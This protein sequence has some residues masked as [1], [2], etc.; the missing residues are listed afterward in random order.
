MLDITN[1][2]IKSGTGGGRRAR[3]V[4]KETEKGEKVTNFPRSHYTLSHLLPQSRLEYSFYKLACSRAWFNF[5]C[6]SQP[7]AYC[8]E[9]HWRRKPGKQTPAVTQLKHRKNQDDKSHTTE[10][11][12]SAINYKFSNRVPRNLRIP[13]RHTLKQLGFGLS[14]PLFS[15]SIFSSVC[16]LYWGSVE[17]ILLG[18][19]VSKVKIKRKKKDLETT[20]LWCCPHEG[21]DLKGV[22]WE[23][24]VVCQCC[25]CFR[26]T[27]NERGFRCSL[28]TMQMGLLSGTSSV[29][30]PASQAD[31]P[32]APHS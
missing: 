2:F 15:Q 30:V 25:W 20:T 27:L 22:I 28:H 17:E 11:L 16:I 31:R 24:L 12:P 26:V 18:K 19:I 32:V 29:Q 3:E 10:N 13:W 1:G 9:S 21:W 5:W 4:R 14:T 8:S 7:F 6:Y 23:S